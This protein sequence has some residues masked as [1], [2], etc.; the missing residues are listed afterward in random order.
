MTG[1]KIQLP[2]IC[3]C[4]RT[5]PARKGR[6]CNSCHMRRRYEKERAGRPKRARKNSG[7][8][9]HETLRRIREERSIW[10]LASKF[11]RMPRPE[12]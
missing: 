3:A 2:K 9:D 10:P 12:V 1:P 8:G 11:L 4:G 5:I 6:I 7:I